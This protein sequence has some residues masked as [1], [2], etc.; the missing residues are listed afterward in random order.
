MIKG[1]NEMDDLQR[2]LQEI[3]EELHKL[4]DKVDILSSLYDRLSE[5]AV[6][7]NSIDNHTY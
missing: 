6:S 5:I 4:N 1:E 3:L 2:T 7:V